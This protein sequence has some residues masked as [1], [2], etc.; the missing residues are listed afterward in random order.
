MFD[1]AS[2]PDL[3]PATLAMVDEVAVIV[4]NKCDLAVLPDP[5]SVAGRAALPVSC[6]TG[7]GMAAL[8]ET[9]AE[10]AAGLLASGDE[11]LLTRARHRVA[12]Q[13]A[14]AALAHF[15]SAPE[16]AELALL[17]EDLRLATRALGR[18]TGQVAVDDLLDRIF[19][20]FCIGK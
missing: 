4:V 15:S 1:G 2:W 16:H 17:A 5:L 9:L 19:A 10:R 8:L 3:D 20:E 14:A 7:A 11:P 12:L 13:G 18:I 6:L